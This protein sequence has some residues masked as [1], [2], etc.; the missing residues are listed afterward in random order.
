MGV[1]CLSVCH[2]ALQE[3][4]DGYMKTMPWVALPWPKLQLR[5]KVGV[6]VG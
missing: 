5:K 4:F 3:Q 2:A 6:L 1:L